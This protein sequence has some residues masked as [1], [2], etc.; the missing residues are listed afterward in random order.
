MKFAVNNVKP[1]KKIHLDEAGPILEWAGLN[2]NIIDLVADSAI[3]VGDIFLNEYERAQKNGGATDVERAAD[4][5]FAGEI[6][7]AAAGASE[8]Y[9]NETT[10]PPLDLALDNYEAALKGVDRNGKGRFSRGLFNKDNS[11]LA[12]DFLTSD[13]KAINALWNE[14][15]DFVVELIRLLNGR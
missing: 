14:V 13:G 6:A 3:H 15:K 10:K 5:R 2:K 4:I 12:P 1:N 8:N 7:V 11:I 9:N